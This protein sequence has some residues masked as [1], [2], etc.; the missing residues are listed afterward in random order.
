MIVARIRTIK[1]GEITVVQIDGI[2]AI[3]ILKAVIHVM[4]Q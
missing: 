3:V 1:E 2:F 4:T